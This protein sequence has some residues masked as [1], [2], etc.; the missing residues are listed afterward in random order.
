MK[1]LTC[2]VKGQSPMNKLDEFEIL[3]D[4]SPWLICRHSPDGTFEF[5]NKGSVRVL[6]YEPSE[7][8]GTNPYDFFHP[9][10]QTAIEEES[11]APALEGEQTLMSEYRFR[12]KD[13]SYVWLRTYTEPVLNQK[14][15]VQSL[16]TSSMDISEDINIRRALER[17]DQ[18][19]E[20]AGNLSAMGAWEFDL[21]TQEIRWTR[22]VFKV[23]EMEHGEPPDFE[24][25]MS[26]YK[27]PAPLSEAIER[28][29]ST[30]EPYN[31]VMPFTSVKGRD[32]WLKTI[33]KPVSVGGQVVKLI[34]VVQ[35]ITEEFEIQSKNREMIQ[36][37]EAQK[38]KLKNLNH[39]LSH[40]LRSP[41]ANLE[42]LIEILESSGLNQTQA[43]TLRHLKFTSQNIRHTLSDLMEAVQL[44][45]IKDNSKEAVN[46]RKV[47]DQVTIG[48]K[49]KI[50][51]TNAHLKTDFSAWKEIEYPK[52]YLESILL[53]MIS[54]ALKYSKAG[55]K[56][57]ILIR[58]SKKGKK[59]VL[60]VHDQ[61]IGMDLVKDGEKLF[62]MGKRLTDQAEGR[63]VG[64]FFTKEQIENMG[65]KIEVESNLGKGSVFRVIF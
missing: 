29:I 5:V 30:G 31:L 59:K 12:K 4:N 54:N 62:A 46:I 23:H 32:K 61:G 52:V 55:V 25:L 63:G 51:A 11:H 2:Q 3:I 17:K 42:I 9:A 48:L 37:L 56:P 7:L 19:L 36:S 39:I 64:L 13:G 26:F 15:E 49:A 10:D 16:V 8:I 53:N 35:D 22:G 33:G 38:Q 27:N 14:G 40:N 65:G 44:I 58:T 1:F 60:E 47:L 34:G 21:E 24:T 28:A 45:Q 6:G 20:E 57:E 43:E 18:L 41:V 50:E